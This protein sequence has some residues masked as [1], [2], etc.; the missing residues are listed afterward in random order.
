MDSC[1]VSA[2]GFWESEGSGDVTL[3]YPREGF[4]Q[5]GASQ[6]SVGV[7][8]KKVLNRGANMRGWVWQGSPEVSVAALTHPDCRRQWKQWGEGGSDSAPGARKQSY[9]ATTCFSGSKVPQRLFS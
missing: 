5:A 2:S 8:Q 7:E 9:L 1:Y 4:L 6:L 3:L